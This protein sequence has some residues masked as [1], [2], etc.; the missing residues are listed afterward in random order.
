MGFNRKVVNMNP[1]PTYQRWREI[2]WR[3]PLTE[4]EQAE[5]RVWLLA[6]P[7]QQLEADLDEKLNQILATAPPP[8]SSNFTARVW[9]E[10]EPEMAREKTSAPREGRVAVVW[11]RKLMPR[12]GLATAVLVLGAMMLWQY[13]GAVQQ[14]ELA[15][16]AQQIAEA[17]PLSDPDVLADFD[18]IRRLTPELLVADEHLLA[19]SDDLLAIHP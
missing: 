19:L 2:A 15:H 17:P 5:L 13:R 6:H 8:V 16:A 4:A 14:K 18:V 10:I 12:L 3:R 7:E 1:D 9:R 11:W